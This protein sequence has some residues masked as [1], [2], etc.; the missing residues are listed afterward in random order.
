MIPAE[1]VE[2]AEGFLSRYLELSS[3]T[4]EQLLRIRVVAT[5]SCGNETCEGWQVVAPENLMPW[6]EET[7]VIK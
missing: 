6:L 2:A 3:L 1:A 5:C 7:V 4:R